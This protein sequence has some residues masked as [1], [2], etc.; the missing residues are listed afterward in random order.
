M[1][2]M[3]L[4][5]SKN[6]VDLTTVD[7][8]RK[9]V[10]SWWVSSVVESV[11]E[12]VE[13]FQEGDMVM[14]V[15][16][17]IAENVE[18]ASPKREMVAPYLVGN[19]SLQ[20]RGIKQVAEGAR[21]RGA[22]KIVGVDLIQEKMQIGK[23]FGV[24]H[25]INP[26]TCGEKKFNEMI[27]EITDGGADYCFERIGLASLMEDAFN[28][29]RANWGK[30]VILGL[31]MHRTPLAINTSLLLRGRTVIGCLFGGLKPKS[32]I[33]FLAQK[34][35]HKELNLDGF[36]NHEVG[37]RDINKAFDSLLEGKSLRCIMRMD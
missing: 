31:E 17:R 36:K 3:K 30:T 37:F 23:K 10:I 11:G 34:Y 2:L 8:E 19:W 28:S 25:F 35:L 29:N 16:V 32:E 21:L 12:H 22:S 9:T 4:F 26:M 27:K 33:P 24:T 15:F 6:V 20:C 5:K 13:E 14:P 1:I 18:T 7:V